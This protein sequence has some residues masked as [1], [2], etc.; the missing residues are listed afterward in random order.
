MTE[1]NKCPRPSTF[2]FSAD[3]PGAVAGTAPSACCGP[4]RGRPPGTLGT[5]LPVGPRARAWRCRPEVGFWS[6]RQ[7]RAAEGLFVS[8]FVLQQLRFTPKVKSPSTVFA[9]PSS[10]VSACPAAS[11]EKALPPS[12][13]QQAPVHLLGAGHVSLSSEHPL[14]SQESQ[15][16]PPLASPPQSVPPAF[17]HNSLSATGPELPPQSQCRARVWVA[18]TQ[19]RGGTQRGVRKTLPFCASRSA[20]L[21]RLG[22]QRP[23]FF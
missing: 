16:V 17:G 3:D 21:S 1:R 5:A 15:P 18:A 23:A 14:H 7:P 10:R 19:P 9:E 2:R 22:A 13:P 6:K 8:V 11:D 4:D 12:P 20:G